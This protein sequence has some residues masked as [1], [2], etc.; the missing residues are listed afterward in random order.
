MKIKLDP[1]EDWNLHAHEIFS[2]F[3][4]EVFVNSVAMGRIGFGPIIDPISLGWFRTIRI[5]VNVQKIT[6]VLFQWRKI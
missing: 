2:I 1:K 6:G 5:I 3:A 4:N